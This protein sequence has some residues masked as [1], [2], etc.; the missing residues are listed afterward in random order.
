MFVLSTASVAA[1]EE[2]V[3]NMLCIY[4]QSCSYSQTRNVMECGPTKFELLFEM[5]DEGK[6]Y[7]TGNV[8]KVKVGVLGMNEKLTMV[9]MTGSEN[10]T[11]TTVDM[12]SNRSIH[13]R[14]IF[15][16]NMI[17]ASQFFGECRVY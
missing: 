10:V 14:N 1:S 12:A 7:M 5:T 2:T 9:E 6:T 4:D 8:D 3:A 16:G 11:T 17:M 13:S 15:I